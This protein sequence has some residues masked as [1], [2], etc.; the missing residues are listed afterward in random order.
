LDRIPELVGEIERRRAVL[1]A[2]RA[3]D[4]TDDGD[5]AD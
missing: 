2:R 1:W 3:R 5:E 4:A